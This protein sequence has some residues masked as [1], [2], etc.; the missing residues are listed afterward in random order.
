MTLSNQVLQT[1]DQWGTFA[2]E[3][4]ALAVSSE[5]VVLTGE[6]VTADCLSCSLTRLHLE[7]RSRR[8]LTAEELTEWGDR[9]AHR[10]RYLLEAVETVEHD[11]SSGK[12]LLRSTPPE[13]KSA[14]TLY[15]EL[16]LESPG[17]LTLERCR[18][19]DKVRTTEPMHLTRQVLEKLLDDL[20][21][22]AP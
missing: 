18:I 11:A 3:P 9:L 7:P 4:H 22:T 14:A 12:L 17:Q 8:E 5:R 15:Y 16:I 1:I 10:V 20:D 13:Q 19:Q 2:D 21:A 6:V